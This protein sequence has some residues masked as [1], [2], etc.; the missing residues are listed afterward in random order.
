MS[1]RPRKVWERTIFLLAFGTVDPF[2]YSTDELED[3]RSAKL[4]RL[5]RN[6]L[7][8]IFFAFHFCKKG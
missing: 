1:L 4:F 5:V 8:H 2:P 3:F 6:V 7:L